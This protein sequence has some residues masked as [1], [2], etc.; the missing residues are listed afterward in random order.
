MPEVR[1][2]EGRRREALQVGAVTVRTLLRVHL[3]ALRHLLSG[4]WRSTGGPGRSLRGFA[5]A[6]G[7]FGLR[8][9]SGRVVDDRRGDIQP[10]RD[11][12][13]ASSGWKVGRLLIAG[14]PDHRCEVLA[15]VQPEG[16]DWRDHGGAGRVLP[17]L[18]TRC[19]VE[20]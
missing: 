6:T 4:V 7:Y 15:A 10:V 2:G 8:H 12:S 14:F 20:R 17:V 18:M 19:G 3:G 11:H 13:A 1:T 9:L 5:P 16:G